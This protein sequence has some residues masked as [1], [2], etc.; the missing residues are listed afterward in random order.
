MTIILIP[1]SAISS[2]TYALL[3]AQQGEGTERKTNILRQSVLVPTVP[4]PDGEPATVV[5]EVE[6]RDRVRELGVLLHA[7]LGV[8][9]PD[10]QRAVGSSRDEGVVAMKRARESVSGCPEEARAER[11]RR[12]RDVQRVVGERV[13]RIGDVLS[14]GG[15]SAVASVGVL[16]RLVIGREVIDRD[17][18]LDRARSPACRVQRKRKQPSALPSDA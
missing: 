9:V 5:G 16:L 12:R 17:T 2:L 1:E 11:T 6:G 15:D 18:S 3:Q 8:V 13:D 7:L 10:G 14:V 4:V